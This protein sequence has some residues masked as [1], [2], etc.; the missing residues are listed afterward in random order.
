MVLP[1]N[2]GET[3]EVITLNLH[4]QTIIMSIDLHSKFFTNIPFLLVFGHPKSVNVFQAHHNLH[5]EGC[6]F[7]NWMNTAFMYVKLFQIKKI[8]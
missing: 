3:F 1:V 6:K 4:T 8:K 7:W 5:L 2:L